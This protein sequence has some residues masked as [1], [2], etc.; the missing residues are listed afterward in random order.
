MATKTTLL[1]N[2]ANK[3]KSKIGVINKTQ[4]GEVHEEI[5]NEVYSQMI[6]ANNSNQTIFQ[7]D[8]TS[9]NFLLYA[10]KVGNT[11]FFSGQI[12]GN[13]NIQGTVYPTINILN[14][15]L[16]GY[17]DTPIQINTYPFNFKSLRNGVVGF[18]F[19]LENKMYFSD[20]VLP[21]Q[22]MSFDGWYQT[23]NL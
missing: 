2:I 13:G 6:I 1:A 14:A 18:G 7:R 5:V 22:S 8:S 9:F 11:V 17:I 15:E 3:I 20:Y 16:Q 23:K 12:I 21:N 4:H 10:K 19:V